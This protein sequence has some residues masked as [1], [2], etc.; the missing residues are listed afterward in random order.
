MET[1]SSKGSKRGGSPEITMGEHH[2]NYDSLMEVR[3][4]RTQESGDLIKE[5]EDF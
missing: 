3:K 4:E 5:M 2:L 1:G